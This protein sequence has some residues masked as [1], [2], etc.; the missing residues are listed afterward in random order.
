MVADG[1]TWQGI[2]R[3]EYSDMVLVANINHTFFI[4]CCF[5]CRNICDALCYVSYSKVL[6]QCPE[7][8]DEEAEPFPLVK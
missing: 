8:P 7:G 4:L 6:K 5:L 1:L 2:V 3:Q